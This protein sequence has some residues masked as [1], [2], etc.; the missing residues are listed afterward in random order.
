M[1]RVWPSGADLATYSVPTT[2]PAPGLFSTTTGWPHTS[3]IFADTRRPMMSVAPP[4]GNGTIRRTGRVGKVC[5][6]AAKDASAA[7]SARERRKFMSLVLV[8][9]LA[10]AH[11]EVGYAAGRDRIVAVE[12]LEVEARA[13]A[14]LLRDPV[15]REQLE[16]ARHVAKI[17]GVEPQPHQAPLPL[18][19]G[20]IREARARVHHGVVVDDD[21]VAALEEEREAVPGIGRDLVEKIQ[22]REV[23]FIERNA[24]LALARCDAR[25]LVAAGELAVAVGEHRGAI[26]RRRLLARSF[27]AEAVVVVTAVER[28]EELRGA[29]AYRVVHRHAAHDDRGAARGRLV[30]A[31]K[32]DHRGDVRVRPQLEVA[33]VHARGRVL[34]GRVDH[35]RD[36]LPLSVL[37]Q[38]SSEMQARAPGAG[39]ELLER[40]ALEG[41]AAQHDEA[42]ARAHLSVTAIELSAQPAEAKIGLRQRVDGRETAAALEGLDRRKHLTTVVA[43]QLDQ[44]VGR[45]EARGLPGE[46]G[47]SVLVDHRHQL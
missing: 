34:G 21:H 19:L 10:V 42:L 38:R 3:C 28:L 31:G 20:E 47:G 4:G 24:A 17:L 45:I 7:A 18:G 36:E 33:A 11:L 23:A 32:R 40:E 8:R 15:L 5:A 44:V 26:G 13:P 12:L 25:A 6:P 46:G 37:R 22:R 29:L 39:G 16:L 9:R 1:P 14:F 41:Q 27:F 35:R 2:V 30:P 43:R